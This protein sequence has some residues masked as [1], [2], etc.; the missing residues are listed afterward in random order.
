MVDLEGE[1]RNLRLRTLK[2]IMGNSAFAV[3]QLNVRRSGKSLKASPRRKR[4]DAMASWTQRKKRGVVVAFR[5]HLLAI[6]I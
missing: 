3:G 4:R 1:D 6:T 5:T 2:E